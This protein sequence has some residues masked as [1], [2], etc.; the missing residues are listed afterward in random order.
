MGGWASARPL[1]KP[2]GCSTLIYGPR[3]RWGAGTAARG[4]GDDSGKGVCHEVLPVPARAREIHVDSSL[5]AVGFYLALGFDEV[6]RGAHPLRVGGE[7]P[8]VFMRKV[9]VEW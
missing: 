3:N 2:S 6:A 4:R 1:P 5:V 9:L 7:L 8:C